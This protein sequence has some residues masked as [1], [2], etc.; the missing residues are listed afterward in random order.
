MGGLVSR[1]YLQNLGGAARCENLI[2]ISSPHRGTS[3]AWL[4]PTLGAADMR[5]GSRF[6]AGLKC[7][8]D[9]LGKIP[10]TSCRT[11]MDLVILPPASSL[12]DRA[13]NLEYPVILHPFMLNSNAVLTDVE[14]RLVKTER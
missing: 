7:T 8:E 14:R 6:L 3:A 9:R 1:Q 13:E 11:P 5:P 12:W 4:Y 10:V 2:T